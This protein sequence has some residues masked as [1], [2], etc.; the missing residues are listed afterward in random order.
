MGPVAIRRLVA[1][2]GMALPLCLVCAPAAAQS[3]E[4][5]A[6]RWDPAVDAT[7]TVGGAAIFLAAEFL[8]A[9]LAPPQCRWCNVD[10]VDARVRD[11]LVWRDPTLADTLSNVAGFAF[12]PLVSVGL[13]ALAAAHEGVLG[14]VGE[15]TL[16]IV[17]AWVVT[18]GVTELTKMLVGRERPFVHELLPGQKPPTPQAA[19]N[20]LSF[21]S[22]HT[23]E[24]FALVAASG[25]IATMRGY[26]WAPLVWS[27]GGALAATTGY[28]RI[29][30]DK[31]WLTDVVVGAL[32]GTSIGFAVPYFF[33]PAVDDPTRVSAS[34][35]L[36][37]RALPAV[38]LMAIAW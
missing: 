13:N 18:A 9:D 20:N 32:V 35:L 30:A 10:S 6:L 17:E 36:R 23:S 19:D 3:G 11:A 37:A 16:L 26:R 25:T 28:L 34:A 31:H 29:A 2:G 12:V 15:D 4:S 14:N 38:N 21:F 22:G 1:A 7:V 24:A 33:H 5:H 8:K 27:A